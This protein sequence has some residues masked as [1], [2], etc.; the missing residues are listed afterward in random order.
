MENSPTESSATSEPDHETTTTPSIPVVDPKALA[1]QYESP[2]P[3]IPA[4]VLFWGNQTTPAAQP[5]ASQQ[6]PIRAPF[7]VTIDIPSGSSQSASV[8]M[9]PMARASASFRRL[10]SRGKSVVSPQ[11]DGH[12]EGGPST[13]PHR[14]IPPSPPP[15]PSNHA[16]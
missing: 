4:N 10:L 3:G 9:S 11:E 8:I 6:L 1:L 13:P 2:A 12:D 15:P 16:S 5:S 14:Q 7:Q